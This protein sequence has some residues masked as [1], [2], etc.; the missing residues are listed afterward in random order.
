MS[1]RRHTMTFIL[2]RD[3]LLAIPPSRS[4]VLMVSAA[5]GSSLKP[6]LWNF[7]VIPA[8]GVVWVG[9]PPISAR[10]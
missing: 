10:R 1:L 7:P 3:C 4:F 9:R 6:I 2:K 5:R 8:N